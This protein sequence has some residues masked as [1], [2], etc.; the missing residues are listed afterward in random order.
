MARFRQQRYHHHMS[1]LRGLHEPTSNLCRRGE[2]WPRGIVYPHIGFF[3]AQGAPLGLLV[4]HAYKDNVWP[5]WQWL[6]Y[7][8]G[9][10]N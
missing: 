9:Q 8:R 4:T 7:E 1:F 3:L 2:V 5:V 6:V 10:T